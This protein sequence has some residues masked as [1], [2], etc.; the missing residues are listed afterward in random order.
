[1]RSA[2]FPPIMLAPAILVATLAVTA[3]DPPP[4]VELG[5]QGSGG[6][7]SGAAS[8]EPAASDPGQETVA[9]ADTDSQTTTPPAATSGAGSLIDSG[10]GAAFASVFAAD[11]GRYFQQA[12]ISARGAFVGSTITWRNPGSGTVGTITPL[13]DRTIGGQECRDFFLTA[14]IGGRQHSET[15]TACKTED[16]WAP[17]A[18]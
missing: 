9:S 13:S 6:I 16:D 4:P 17:R 14:T 8:S 7:V 15:A 12:E 11:D 5:P 2:A 3:C 18:S 1:M 10:K